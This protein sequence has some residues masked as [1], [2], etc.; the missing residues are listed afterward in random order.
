MPD[1]A[2]MDLNLPDGRAVEVLESP[3][4]A[5]RFPVL[6]MTSFGSEQV[7]VEAMKAGA[8]DYTVKS[9]EAFAAMP[10]AVGRVLREWGL[11]QQRRRDAVALER[12]RARYQQLVA[13]LEDVVFSTDTHGCI[14]YVSPAIRRAYGYRP[15]QLVGRHIAEFVHPEDL[16]EVSD[17]MLRAL[18]GSVETVEF[19]A[20]DQ[21]GR[22]RHLRTK[23]GR[24]LEDERVAG[25]D[26][27]LIDLTEQRWREEQLRASQ[28]LE[29][30]GR[31]AG[32]V[33]HD[34]N[35]LLP[36]PE[37]CLHVRLCR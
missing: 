30:I 33:A 27:V 14:E 21:A 4:E 24:R 10:H 20:V 28:R 19:R 29:A 7:A 17:A 1:I 34:F 37:G 23:A 3:P 26:G 13:N 35:N 25:L 12:S 8:L 32:G 36:G 11:L 31:L 9:P 22:V 15:A 16:Q 6:I 5:G 2:L 18:A